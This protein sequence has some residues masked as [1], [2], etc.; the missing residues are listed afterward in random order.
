[1]F[2]N[3]ASTQ[4]WELILPLSRLVYFS[5]NQLDPKK[6]SAL[7][8]LSDILSASNRNNKLANIT[9]ALVFDDFWFIQ[10]LSST[11]S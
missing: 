5:E 11:A 9:G 6:G 3:F 1:M 8:Q 4:K 10:V 2:Q 7:S